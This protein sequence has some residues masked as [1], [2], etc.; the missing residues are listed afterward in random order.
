MGFSANIPAG[1]YTVRISHQGYF[2]FS[3]DVAVTASQTVRPALAIAPAMAHSQSRVTLSWG[4]S[5]RDLD[6]YLKVPTG[7]LV[8]WR[9]LTATRTP[10]VW[11][12]M[13]S[14]AMARRQ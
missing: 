2:D 12:V 8:N 4:A 3:Q 9:Q 11:I 14:M 6:A 13:T 10:C 5:P 1:S 7:C